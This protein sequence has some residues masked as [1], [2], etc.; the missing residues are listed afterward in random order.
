MTGGGGWAT[1][2]KG[3]ATQDIELFTKYSSIYGIG[4]VIYHCPAINET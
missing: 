4:M 2:K 1:G 3:R